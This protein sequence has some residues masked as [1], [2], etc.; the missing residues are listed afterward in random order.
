MSSRSDIYSSEEDLRRFKGVSPQQLWLDEEPDPDAALLVKLGE[1]LEVATG[2][3]NTYT[4]RDFLAEVA[5]GE[6]TKVPAAIEMV[7]LRIGANVVSLARAQKKTDLVKI[8]DYTEKLFTARVFT[9][10]MKEELDLY[11]RVTKT[12]VNKVPL[13]MSRVKSRREIEAEALEDSWQ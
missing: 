2:N 9:Q 3:I 12:A 7:A 11:V 8:N 1:Y 4:G 5:N 13:K 6:I 10:D